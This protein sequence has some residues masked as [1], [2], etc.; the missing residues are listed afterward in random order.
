MPS[1]PHIYRRI[2]LGLIVALA[3]LALAAGTP[4]ARAAGDGPWA[5]GANYDGQLGNGAT[6]ASSVPVAGTGLGDVVA[7]G[8]GAGH[9]VAL[10]ADGSLWA[11]GYNRNG[12]LGYPTTAL[13]SFDASP[14]QL[15]PQR[16]PGLSAVAMAT[17]AYHTLIRVQDG[18]LWAWGFNGYGELGA[19]PGGS[20]PVHVPGLSNVAALAGGHVH[21]LA[22]AADGVVWSWGANYYGQL[23][24]S[25]ANPGGCQY[26]LACDS[27]PGQVAGLGDIV[28][29]F[30]GP[31]DRA[32]HSFALARDGSVWAWGVNNT[33]QL[34]VATSEACYV[35]GV[36][37]SC[38]TRPVPVP[39]ASGATALAVGA[40]H[41][42]ALMPDGTVMAWGD[43]SRGELGDGTLNRRITPVIVPGLSDVVAIAAGYNSSFALAR[44]GSVWAWGENDSGQLGDGTTTDRPSPVQVTGLSGITQIAAGSAYVLALR[45]VPDRT[46]PVITS[47][48]S[49][50]K[51][52]HDWYTSDVVVSWSV[53]DPESPIVARSECDPVTISTDTAGTTLTCTATSGGG[54]ASKSITI[55]RDATPPHISAASDRAANTSGWYNDDVRVSY[56][57]SD[58]LSGIPAGNCP[59]DQVLSSE[60][61]AVVSTA[62]TVIDAAGNTS[63]PSNVVTVKIDKTAPGLSPAVSLN[64]VL[65]NGSATVSAD[66]TDSLSGLAEQSCG[67]LATSSVG[68]QSVTC[69]ATD[70]AGNTGSGTAAYRVI[71]RFDGFLQPINDTAH[72]LVCGSSCPPSIFK[73]GG[74]VPVKFQLKDA[75]GNLVQS[76]SLPLWLTPVKGAATSAPIDEG[77]FTDAPSAGISYSWNGQEYQYNWKT[78]GFAAGFYWRIGVMLDDGQTYYVSIG[79]R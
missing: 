10:K 31:V 15:T 45:Y 27:T 70:L 47:N 3:L 62:Q 6:A 76:A 57:C 43:N 36:A 32:D 34:G 37:Y 23:G 18:S 17:G 2:A 68:L 29:I 30:A 44:D 39:G 75:N 59:A 20:G 41:S 26:G 51:G 35:Y 46:P 50:T 78:K 55:K 9:S 5:W 4:P 13:C 71:Y 79:L 72:P 12:E 28:A 40:F 14:C 22:L 60:G 52:D 65:L 64:P 73:G 53:S 33:G 66:A 24:R 38:S 77:A 42:L 61:A 58:D 63:P 25:S 21:S 19:P 7:I 1:L 69:T 48:V 8:A 11:W 56:T 16:V 67:A 49:G 74:T 54:T